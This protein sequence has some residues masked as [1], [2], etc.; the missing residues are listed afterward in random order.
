MQEDLVQP[1]PTLESLPSTIKVPSGLE[2]IA[3]DSAPSNLKRNLESDIAAGKLDEQPPA[4]R[5][6]HEE[7]PIWARRAKNTTPLP[8]HAAN[9]KSII[10]NPGGLLNGHSTNG[11]AQPVA[12]S[13]QEANGPLGPWEPSINNLIPHEELTR[14][15]SDFLFLN[16]VSVP[17]IGE[18]VVSCG[19]SGQLEIEAKL[20][21]I[22]DRKTDERLQLPILTESVINDS[23]TG[24][25]V[26]FESS[27][28]EVS[29]FTL[30]QNV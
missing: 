15:I 12:Q 13:K 14:A 6:R 17:G 25:D 4:K 19:I 30:Q 1:S 23:P 24:L 5:R 11:L 26:A 20:G 3:A 21:K 8:K 16:V 27:M 7:I 29:V 2:T 22:I 9:P 28:T 10:G 18:P